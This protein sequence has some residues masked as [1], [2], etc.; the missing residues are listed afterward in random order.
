MMV[1]CSVIYPWGTWFERWWTVRDSRTLSWRLWSKSLSALV[2]DWDGSGTGP[3]VLP[4]WPKATLGRPRSGKGRSTSGSP[5]GPTSKMNALA[6]LEHSWK[7]E[8][9]TRSRVRHLNQGCGREQKSKL[10]LSCVKRLIECFFSSL[11]SGYQGVGNMWVSGRKLIW[12]ATDGRIRMTRYVLIIILYTH[13]FTVS[14][15]SEEES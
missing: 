7:L 10:C 11:L 5:S 3:E 9:A 1:A 12:V 14:L 13:A 8:R 4:V 2:W 15:A 6:S